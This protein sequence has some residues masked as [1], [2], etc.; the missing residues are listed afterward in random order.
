MHVSLDD[1]LKDS[2]EGKEA[3]RIISNCVHCGFC[4]AVC[5]TY[6]IL[7]DDLDSPRGRIYLIKSL[8]EGNRAGR[9]SQV[10]LDRCLA[11]HACETACPSGVEYGKLLDIGRGLLAGQVRRSP[12]ARAI[13]LILKN[14]LP[15]RN[16]FTFLLRMGQLFRPLLPGPVRAV[17]PP[18]PKKNTAP[19][20]SSGHDTRVILFSGCVQDALAP[21]INR[22]AKRMLDRAGISA[23]S[24]KGEGCCGAIHHHM[25]DH[26]R[27]IMFMRRNIDVWRPYIEEGIDAIVFTASGCGA[28]IKQYGYVLQQI[29]EYAEQAGHVSSIARDISQMFDSKAV[30][31]FAAMP[32]KRKLRAVYQCPCTLQ[33]ALKQPGITEKLLLDLGVELI[34]GDQS[35]KCCG[36]AGV[37]SLLEPALSAQLRREKIDALMKCRPDLILTSNIGCLHHLQQASEVPVNHWIEAVDG[38]L[39]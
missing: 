36:S 12:G 34:E 26:Q 15:Y 25:P 24:V 5:P 1:R 33:H 17:I 14:I 31:K 39:H 2:S 37:Y 9:T 38:L 19:L 16:R 13:R 27:A 11:C 6:S 23:I 8:V 3:G 7:G 35:G 18:R 10:H 22:A 29:P 20:L 21:G 28:M 4:T 32:K 30:E